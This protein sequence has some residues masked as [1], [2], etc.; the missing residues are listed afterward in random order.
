MARRLTAADPDQAAV[1]DRLTNE[2]DA[3]SEDVERLRAE[4]ERLSEALATLESEHDD[5]KRTT[6][7]VATRLDSS[8]DEL[9]RMIGD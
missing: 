3:L 5:V 1:I 8:I 9:D 4:C 2:R 6:G 7:Q